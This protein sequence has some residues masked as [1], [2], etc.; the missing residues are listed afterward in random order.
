MRANGVRAEAGQSGFRLCARQP[1][2]ACLEPFK[3]VRDRRG[4]EVLSVRGFLT[5]NGCHSDVTGLR[6]VL[7]TSSPMFA[8]LTSASSA[9][10][11][12]DEVI[13]RT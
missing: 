9:S 12:R 4:G 11:I 6:R 10:E 3:Y 5:E 1:I 13:P 8:P 2:R 7:W